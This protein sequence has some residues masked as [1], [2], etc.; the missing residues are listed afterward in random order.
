MSWIEDVIVEKPQVIPRFQV[1]IAQ[2][3]T[4][5]GCYFV[6]ANFASA[7]LI[8]VMQMLSA[9]KEH[10]APTPREERGWEEVVGEITDKLH[11]LN[12]EINCEH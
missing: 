10:I 6:K 7:C 8:V 3:S 5:M 12:N 2:V 9:V 4:R 11:L 1:D